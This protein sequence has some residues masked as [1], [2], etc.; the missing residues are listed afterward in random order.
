MKILKFLAFGIVLVATILLLL[1][2]EGDI[3]VDVID[4]KYGSPSSQFM[5][6]ENGS[7]IHYRD[8]GNRRG[9]PVVLIHG[10][11]ASLHT[12]TSWVELLG[13][14][15]RII[16]LDLPAHGLTGA[17]PDG[18]YS[19]QAYVEAI[20]NVVDHLKLTTFTLG[21]NSMGGDVAWHFALAYPDSLE[22][23]IL[24]NATG[25]SSWEN[26]VTKPLIFDLLAKDWFRSIASMLDP[27]YLIEQAVQTAYN[28][29]ATVTDDLILRYYHMAMRKGSREAIIAR[30]STREGDVATEEQLSSIQMPTLVMW[31]RND[32]LIDVSVAH[33]FETTLPNVT[34]IIYDEAGHVP[35]E[36]IP[37]RSATDVKDFLQGIR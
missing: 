37:E 26:Q 23:M 24:V 25:L 16:T 11:G 27:Y 21:G 12:W 34:L 28:H 35:M 20:K 5:T 4:A 10:F 13:D 7:R 6:L 8:E 30:S 22:S 19:T 36:E 9:L 14:N 3:P 31:G 15:Y 17:V 33:L 2:Y 32:E 29:S 1:L 18:D